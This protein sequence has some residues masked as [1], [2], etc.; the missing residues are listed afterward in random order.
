MAL[1]APGASFSNRSAATR[2]AP[3]GSR[4]RGAGETFTVTIGTPGRYALAMWKVS[5][6]DVADQGRYSIVVTSGTAD[7]ES[8]APAGHAARVGVAEPVGALDRDPLRT[9][10]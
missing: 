6:A 2:S 4:P 8:G 3:F 9:R 10:A 1:H 5:Q 7:V